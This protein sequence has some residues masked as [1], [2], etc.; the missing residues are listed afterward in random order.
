MLITS[1]VNMLIVLESNI[2]IIKLF[3][4]GLSHSFPTMETEINLNRLKCL[5]SKSC[6]FLGSKTVS[7][8][9][10]RVLFYFC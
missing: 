5:V 1:Q 8:E 2:I 3:V 6:F 7:M 9:Q 4:L 10:V